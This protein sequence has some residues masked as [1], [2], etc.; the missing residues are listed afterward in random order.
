M[1]AHINSGKRLRT[2]RGREWE[3]RG[4][5]SWVTLREGSGVLE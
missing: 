3:I 2:H 4:M 1:A 5:G